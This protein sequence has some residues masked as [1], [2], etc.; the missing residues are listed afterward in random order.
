ME[1]VSFDIHLQR[2]AEEADDREVWTLLEQAWDA[3][4]DQYGYS[5]VRR[6]IGEA[7]LYAA[8]PGESLDSLMFSRPAGG[9]EIFDLIVDVARAGRMVIMPAG[10][11]P[12]V[13]DDGGLR[14]FPDDIA[15]ALGH[16]VVV[17]DGSE[18]L[19]LVE[20]S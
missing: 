19:E 1:T 20:N 8:Q 11:P 6:G 9:T 16:P 3:P 5:R 10:C 14:T 13:T 12:C 15:E 2:V 7:D 18:L 17:T 4:P